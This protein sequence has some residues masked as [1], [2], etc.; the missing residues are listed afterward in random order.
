MYTFF[1][2]LNTVNDKINTYNNSQEFKS[3]F[4]NAGDYTKY[5]SLHDAMVELQLPSNKG[6]LLNLYDFGK[7]LNQPYSDLIKDLRN[8]YSGKYYF[9]ELGSKTGNIKLR[10][11]LIESEDT[12]SIYVVRYGES[13]KDYFKN[14]LK[15]ADDLLSNNIEDFI[16]DKESFNNYNVDIFEFYNDLV[17]ELRNRGYGLSS[18]V[19]D[20]SKDEVG[21]E[22]L[23]NY[24]YTVSTLNEELTRCTE[25][26]HSISD[27]EKCAE[28]IARAKHMKLCKH[29][30]IDEVVEFSD[31]QVIVALCDED[32]EDEYECTSAPVFETEDEFWSYLPINETINEKIEK[33]E[34]IVYKGFTIEH[35]PYTYSTEEEGKEFDVNGYVIHSPYYLQSSPDKPKTHLPLYCED[36]EGN[37][38]NLATLEDAKKYIDDYLVPKK[39]KVVIKHGDEV[40]YV[41]NKDSLNEDYIVY[42]TTDDLKNVFDAFDLCQNQKQ[43]REL[44]KAVH[45]AL[46]Q[47]YKEDGVDMEIWNK[48]LEAIKK[49]NIES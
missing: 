11:P 7:H 39:G 21:K 6:K 40:H 36:E 38:I 12:S 19:I 42:K 4:L 28:N 9:V 33:E 20:H 8:D 45:I 30:D 17:D 26:K 41:I 29:D 32:A 3:K 14:I 46:Y 44:A 35:F 23:F 24:K 34:D 37:D 1:E 22:D 15:T 47:T 43:K 10:A 5:K 31:G 13:I 18:V 2:A 16:F 27:I 25:N 48:I 49:F